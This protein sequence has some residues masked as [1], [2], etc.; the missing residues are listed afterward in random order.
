VLLITKKHQ[1]YEL[2]KINITLIERQNQ[3]INTEKFGFYGNYFDSAN[4]PQI[5]I[6]ERAQQI[7]DNITL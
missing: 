7:K 3:T 4:F 1:G 5:E 2:I 6:R